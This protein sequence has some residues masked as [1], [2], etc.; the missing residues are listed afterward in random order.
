M[1]TFF[2]DIFLL[3]FVVTLL[4]TPVSQWLARIFGVVA[5]PSDRKMHGDIMPQFGGLA[6]FVAF[7][8]AVFIL[9][10]YQGSEIVVLFPQVFKIWLAGLAV[11]VVGTMDDRI[12]IPA[13]YKLMFQI[14]VALFLVA[15]GVV[16]EFLANPFT[17]K[18]IYLG[19]FA[20]IISVS[21]IVILM[22]AVNLIDGLDGLASGVVA[23]SAFFLFVIALLKGELLA[24]F[25][26]IILFGMTVGFLRYN[27]FPAT[28]FM[29]DSGALLLG[30][31]LAI[32]S[33][34]GV[35]KSSLTVALAVPLLSLLIPLYDLLFS[36]IRRIHRREHIFKPDKGHV[37][38]RLLNI[39][40]NQRQAV[41]RI[42]LVTFYFNALAL[43]MALA[44]NM[45][46]PFVCFLISVVILI[47][48][49]QRLEQKK[50]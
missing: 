29:G 35:L 39:G 5:V 41:V 44:N 27:F 2:I 43:I 10:L 33:I 24:S 40:Y 37:H 14:A 22:N 7:T 9:P 28:T 17:G 45:L 18:L 23:I 13:I 15:N 11:F 1:I 8:A 49:S 20:W 48:V 42:Y 32:S 16:I 6:F 26:L 31:L 46:V 36:V 12:N 38:H 3:T 21:W 50:L 19:A 34:E 47:F 25:L 4:I 30:M